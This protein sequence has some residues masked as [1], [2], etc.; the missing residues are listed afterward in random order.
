MTHWTKHCITHNSA[1]SY[2]CGGKIGEKIRCFLPKHFGAE[3]MNGAAV[4]C[5]S[6]EVGLKGLPLDLLEGPPMKITTHFIILY[7]NIFI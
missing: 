7:D 5:V 6:S 3:M 2:K 1:N 4:L